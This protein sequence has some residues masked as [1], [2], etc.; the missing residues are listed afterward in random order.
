MTKNR[1]SEPEQ[2][3]I[4]KWADVELLRQSLESIGAKYKEICT[5]VCDVVQKKYPKL[6]YP[7][8]HP[9]FDDGRGSLGLGRR[10]WPSMYDGWTNGFYLSDIGLVN[11]TSEEE[12]HPSAAIWLK[13]P[14][15]L[16]FNLT[17]AGVRVRREAKAL[18]TPEQFAACKEDD[19]W[20]CFWYPLP[21]S[22]QRLLEMLLKERAKEFVDCLASHFEDL[23]KFTP[24][25][26]DLFQ[27]AKKQTKT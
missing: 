17:E 8:I 10:K 13:P 25:L 2:F 5:E 24:V 23:A 7:S 12:A 20:T 21:E 19:K 9:D 1:F 26:D 6:D 14:S 16:G 27:T 4:E 11:L 15:S 22:K 18:M 3:L